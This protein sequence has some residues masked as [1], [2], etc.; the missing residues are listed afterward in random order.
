MGNSKCLALY[1][2]ITTWSNLRRRVIKKQKK[3]IRTCLV[4]Y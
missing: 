1:P 4:D 2:V 3:T